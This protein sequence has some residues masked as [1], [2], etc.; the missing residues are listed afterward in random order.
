MPISQADLS[1]IPGSE[2]VVQMGTQ[3]RRPGKDTIWTVIAV[4]P[5]VVI[6][7][8]LWVY[9]G[10]SAEG[11]MQG[12]APEIENLSDWILVRKGYG[13]NTQLDLFHENQ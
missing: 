10:V 1:S 13:H 2:K 3:I 9:D 7:A 5:P 12:Y 8:D 4:S 6:L 11:T